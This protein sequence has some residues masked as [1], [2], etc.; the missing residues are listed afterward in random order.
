[1][2]LEAQIREAVLEGRYYQDSRVY[3]IDEKLIAKALFSQNGAESEFE[4][5][6]FLYHNG[7]QVPQFYDCIYLSEFDDKER[8]LSHYIVMDKIIG[9]KG[10]E[11]KGNIK[12]LAVGQ[13]LVEV[14]KI[15]DLG[16]EPRDCDNPE[17]VIF[18][19]EENKMYLIDFEFYE[20]I[21][22]PKNRQKLREQFK[23]AIMNEYEL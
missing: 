4:I 22:G 7:V 6:K 3:D 15:I 5:G 17:N 10:S 19:F 20:F 21:K 1:M 13:L 23:H 8:K 18:N 12:D 2:N 9:K 11:L 16:T 14:E